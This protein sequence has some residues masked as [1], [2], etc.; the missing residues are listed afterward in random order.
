MKDVSELELRTI[1]KKL[2]LN[3]IDCLKAEIASLSFVDAVF[4]NGINKA[5]TPLYSPQEQE[6][7]IT[8]KI[9]LQKTIEELQKKIILQ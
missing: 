3:H 9:E 2:T 4:Y 1:T 7:M 5:G 8:K 6:D